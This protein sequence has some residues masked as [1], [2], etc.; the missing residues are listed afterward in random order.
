V[1]E[2]FH[3]LTGRPRPTPGRSRNMAA[4]RSRNTKAE[5]LLRQALRDRGLSGYR[6]NLSRLPGKPDA[7]YTRWRVAVFVDGAY[8]HGHPDHY[9]FGRLGQYWDDKIRRT[10]QRDRE[11]QQALEELGYTVV[12]FWDFEVLQNADRCASVVAAALLRAGRQIASSGA[13]H[14]LSASASREPLTV[15]HPARSDYAD[16]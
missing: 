14:P 8:W 1:G 4:I 9:T 2:E 3:P 12:R 10:Q 5:R 7:A 11:Q 6:C 15:S 16:G 13:A